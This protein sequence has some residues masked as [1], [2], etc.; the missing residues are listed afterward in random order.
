[1]R[2]QPEPSGFSTLL[3]CG[4]AEINPYQGVIITYVLDANYK[5][6]LSLSLNK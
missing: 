1:M 4:Q 3:M 5:S 6:V 2:L